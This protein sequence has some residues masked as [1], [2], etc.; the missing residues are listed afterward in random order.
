MSK[1][2]EIA[3]FVEAGLRAGHSPEELRGALATA[4]WAEREIEQ[5]LALWVDGGL[6]LPVP[7]PRQTVSGR[8]VLLYGLMGVALLC[9]TWHLVSLGFALIARWLPDPVQDSFYDADSMRWSIAVLI[10][11]LPLFLWLNHRAETAARVDPG[12]RKTPVRRGFG[13]TA[14]FLSALVLLGSAVTV[15]YSGLS[16]AL[17]L[18]FLAQ[19]ALVATVA[20]V[21]LIWGRSFLQDS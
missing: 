12:Q 14:L 13:A 18:A 6:R 11:L 20:L 4:G 17:T 9:I 15:V 5:A 10:V 16:G 8:D 21:V 1:P 7:R 19:T 2:Q 3:Q